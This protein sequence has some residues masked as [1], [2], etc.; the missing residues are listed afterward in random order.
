MGEL[1]CLAMGY[2]ESC[3][4]RWISNLDATCALVEIKAPDFVTQ[5]LR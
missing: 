3:R 5:R 1:F 4:V 2:L